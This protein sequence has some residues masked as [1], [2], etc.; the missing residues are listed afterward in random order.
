LE[1]PERVIEAAEEAGDPIPERALAAYEI[2]PACG[3]VQDAW[4]T[5]HKQRSF[6]GMTGLPIPLA[7]PSVV[8]YAERHGFAETMAE[9]DDFVE[10]IYVQESEYLQVMSDKRGR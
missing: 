8:V 4:L 6:D 3:P 9:L 5:L 10:L 2:F 1:Q 7:Y